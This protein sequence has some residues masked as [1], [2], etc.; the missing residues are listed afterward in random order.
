MR[1][2]LSWLR[3]YV[4]LPDGV[5]ARELAGRL[6]LAGLEVETVDRLGT[7]ITG[8]VVYGRV[9][10]IEELTGFKKPI[11]H[12][13]V[14]VGDANGT[15]DP[16]EI[17]CGARNFA[18]GDLVVVS[19]PGAE[20]PGGFRIGARKTYGRMSAG[21]ICSATELGLWDDHSGIVVLP[22]GFGAPGED[23]LGPL[24]VR[25]DVL[26]IAVTPDRGYALSLRGVA[27]DAAALYGVDFRDP[28]DIAVDAPTG[29]GW[30][31]ET[32]PAL[33]D[34][35][36]LRGATGFD[37]D[38]PTPLWM[39]RRLHQ[40]GV[41][42]IS[43]A[44]D[45]TNYVMLELGQPLHAWDRSALRGPL[46]VRAAEAGEK[47]E[48]L[49]HLQRSLDP[50][51]IVI[52]DDSGPVNIAGV[53]GGLT[54]EISA[55]STEV[56]VEAGH[57]DAMRIARASRR[58]QL[59]SESSRRFER[60]VDSAVQLVAATR[61]AELLAELGGASVETAY[62]RID[63]TVPREPITVSASHAGSV[64]GV[65]YPAGTAENRLRGIGC[66]V[67]A[68]GDLLRVVPPTWRPDITDPNDLAE[69]VIRFEGYENIP[70]IPPR[71]RSGRGLTAGQR[72]RR[73]VGRSLADAG[74]HEVLTYPF[75]GGRDLDGLQLPADDARRD[76]LRLVNPL[77]EEEPL[78]RT[79]L[80]PGLFKTLARN[81]GR[82]LTDV[83][84]FEVALVYLPKPGAARAP[85]PPVDRAPG[86]EELAAIDAAVPHQP[87]RVGA[88]LA[89]DFERAG[90]WGPGRAATW[91]DAVQ[92]AREVARTAGVEL[93][94]EAAQHA[95]WHPG[96]CAAL[97]V[98][99][100]GERLL[101]GH[102]GELHPRTVQA[103]GLPERSAAVEVDLD[104]IERARPAVVAPE[105]S[106]YPVAT[107]DV[108][109]AVD[110]SVPVGLVSAALTEGAGDLLE[111]VR[112]FDV[113][114]GEQVGEG[115]KSVAFTLRFRAGDRTLTAEEAGAARDAAVA[116]AAE[117]TGAV[118]RG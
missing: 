7:D 26:D 57:F 40:S 86:A 95:P 114:T 99:A 19:L 23:A 110:A 82:G 33:C 29:E 58:H 76:S 97:Y 43:L 54:T 98:R 44:V 60:G 77:N 45:V 61:A 88:V 112:L 89:G 59:S 13:R 69:E 18:E 74:Y 41:R 103:F 4:D 102:A 113:Y 56:L 81:V 63:R 84:L 35:Y 108:A 53:M 90:W 85:L 48:T 6:T 65:D 38:A 34:G 79:T 109:L 51:D 92:A 31:A 42:P 20:L 87:R 12:C 72:L 70:S 25:E 75:V 105:V 14:D 52:A 83:A 94:A 17:V 96:R 100:D 3:E 46:R 118:L 91:A 28:A 15:G 116:L 55:T 67:E 66:R 101:V 11:R 24:G 8:P 73:A 27:R 49:D 71:A 21:M 117:R 36:V 1:V 64:A 80:L 22:E 9:L 93:E 62:T 78:L 39:K 104:L 16:Q 68:D 107:Q 50:D 115:R 47:L 5:T 32:D 37:P 2:P 30:A 106:T 10:E 111:S